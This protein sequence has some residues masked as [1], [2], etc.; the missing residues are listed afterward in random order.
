MCIWGTPEL[1]RVSQASGDALGMR[2]MLR[3]LLDCERRFRF[4]CGA[5]LCLVRC[6]GHSPDVSQSCSVRPGPSFPPPT[7][8]PPPRFMQHL[9]RLSSSH[10]VSGGFLGGRALSTHQCQHP[11]GA[12]DRA[13][14]PAG[15]HVFA[16][17][18]SGRAAGR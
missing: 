16:N 18:G 11:C 2:P 6:A 1:L 15:R 7:S 12:K 4:L 17:T 14:V 3:A 9:L 13:G 8:L 5:F 10:A